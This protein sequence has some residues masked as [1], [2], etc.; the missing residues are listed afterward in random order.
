MRKILIVNDSA[1]INKILAHNF[2][3]EGFLVETVV[4]GREGISRAK[5]NKYDIILLDYHLPDINGDLVARA[6]KNDKNAKGIPLYFISALEKETMDKVIA[7]TG[8]QGWF[9]VTAEVEAVVKN[10]KELLNPKRCTLN[11][12]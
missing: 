9:D 4:T 3:A 7:E 1:T 2:E 6:V 8:A 11:Y 5:E 12:E 10:I